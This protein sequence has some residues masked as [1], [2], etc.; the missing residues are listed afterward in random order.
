MSPPAVTLFVPA[1][2]PDRL[3]KAIRSGADAV[4]L[5][6]EDGLGGD[7]AQ[8]GFAALARVVG[9]GP[10]Q[11][12][13]VQIGVRLPVDGLA[14]LPTNVAPLL[15]GLDMVRLP[16]IVSAQD[17]ADRVSELSQRL[18]LRSSG[19]PRFEVTV[20]SAAAVLASGEIAQVP[21]VGGFVLGYAD[22]AADLGLPLDWVRH[23]PGAMAHATATVLVAARA[24]GLPAP[25]AGATTSLEAEV[26]ERES[27]W[28]RA[29]GCAGK[30]AIHP[31]QIAPIRAG[32][33]PSDDELAW[34]TEVL[35][36]A[37]HDRWTGLVRGRFVDAA[38][39]RQAR[40]LVHQHPADEDHDD[41]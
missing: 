37:T 36:V 27:V 41:A 26:V 18:D 35:E 14:G 8:D 23:A 19:P 20:E 39:I 34:A 17:A 9:E 7:E 5:D 10:P 3:A 30:S 31:R 1:N 40:T 29:H 16:K 32:L 2:R 11:D 12:P 33:R 28:A 21:G 15:A 6:L 24:A 13:A 4:M 22:L 38:V 25:A